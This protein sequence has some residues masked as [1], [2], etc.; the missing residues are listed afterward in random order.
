MGPQERN[1]LYLLGYWVSQLETLEHLQE[2]LDRA[3]GRFGSD[4]EAQLALDR[5]QSILNGHRSVVEDALYKIPR[6]N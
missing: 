2:I 1:H 3:R 5:E 6:S 4:Q